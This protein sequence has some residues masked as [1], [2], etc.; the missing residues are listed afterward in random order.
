M[1]LLYVFLISI[2]T[3]LSAA[4]QDIDALI[5]EADRLEAVPDEKAA[6]A[7]FKEALK[8]R[9]T[10]LHALSKSSELCSRIGQRQT[11]T[12]VRDDY[13]TA[14][15]IYAQTA[16]TIDSTNSEANTSMAIMLGRSTLTKS[17]KE[18]VASAKDLKKYVEAAIKSNPS[19]FLA[20]HV[21][22]RWHYEISNLNMVERAA[23]KVFYGGFPPSSLK[24]SIAAFEKSKA[25]TSGFILNYLELAKAYH[26]NNQDT[27]A[28]ALLKE[29]MLIPNHTEDDP[30]IK[31]TGKK[32]L[33]DW[34]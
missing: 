10:H 32:Y 4:S 11:N 1:K 34:Q 22:G 12:K 31:E 9:P 2:F 8:V 20:W 28:I 17:G 21:L 13:Y 5:K 26:R 30:T 14:A 7:K 19:N 18:K 27:K 29:M 25:L 3:F 6:L 24:E 16:L 33:E 23:V 15:R